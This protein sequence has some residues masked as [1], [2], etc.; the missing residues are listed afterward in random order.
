MKFTNILMI[1]FLH[2]QV[3][4][5]QTTGDG[6]E[7]VPGSLKINLGGDTFTINR[8]INLGTKSLLFSKPPTDAVYTGSYEPFLSTKR[9]MHSSQNSVTIRDESGLGLST[10]VPLEISHWSQIQP[11]G[12]NNNTM[13]IGLN[14]NSANTNS[15]G[16]GIFMEPR[17][18]FGGSQWIENHYE[19]L[20]VNDNIDSKT[21]IRLWSSQFIHRGTRQ[22]SSHVFDF[23]GTVFSYMDLFSNTKI[24]FG[25][26]GNNSTTVK[27]GLIATTTSSLNIQSASKDLWL[28]NSPN[29]NQ[30]LQFDNWDNVNFNALQDSKQYNFLVVKKDVTSTA[31]NTFSLGKSSRRFNDIWSTKI[32]S[33]NVSFS[34]K[35]FYESPTYVPPARLYGVAIGNTANTKLVSFKGYN[36][37][38]T[39]MEIHENNAIIMHLPT[40]NKIAEANAAGLSKNQLF[41]TSS[42]VLMVNTMPI[43]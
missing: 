3:S 18:I 9:L 43:N 16:M 23:R 11:D 41:K 42:G 37:S 28:I 40:Y 30:V 17:W 34:E 21:N 24:S 1:L 2:L 36:N 27:M 31:T 25:F 15:I 8:T 14:T 7:V 22:E 10:D 12:T 29:P 19:L 32:L 35:A 13:S 26:N 6:V 20:N 4:I 5:A 39:I 38:S 33:T